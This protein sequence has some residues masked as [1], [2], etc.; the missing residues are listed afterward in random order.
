MHVLEQQLETIAVSPREVDDE[1]MY[2]DVEQERREYERKE[3]AK[4]RAKKQR[5]LD[6]ALSAHNTHGTASL[7]QYQL[8]VQEARLPVADMS[9]FY[10]LQNTWVDALVDSVGDDDEERARSLLNPVAHAEEFIEAMM[11]KG[12]RGSRGRPTKPDFR[13]WHASLT[14][15]EHARCV[16]VTHDLLAAQAALLV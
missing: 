7:A 1:S 10:E 4:R 16:S 5:K 6:A 3:A 14:P 13:P 15:A 12:T 9:D 2:R 8:L 11:P